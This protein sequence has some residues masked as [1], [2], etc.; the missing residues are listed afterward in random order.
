MKVNFSTVL[1][2]LD[3]KPI[4]TSETDKTPV[5]LAA[6]ARMAM[7]SADDPRNPDDA[8]KKMRLFDTMML[9]RKGGVQEITPEQATLIKEKIGMAYNPVI[10]GRS[11]ALL[12][13]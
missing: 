6:V 12:N 13:G 7:T 1:L 10:Y 9:I 3:D 2:D 5:T 11:V 4:H 8:A